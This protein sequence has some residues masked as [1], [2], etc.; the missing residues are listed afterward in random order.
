MLDHESMAM[1]SRTHPFFLV[2]QDR[3]VACTQVVKN[4][5]GLA[6]A[7]DEG[8]REISGL[9][10]FN[11]RIISLTNE[12]DNKPVTVCVSSRLRG[13]E[14]SL[15]PSENSRSGRKFDG[16]LLANEK[17]TLLMDAFATTEIDS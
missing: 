4:L 12:L 1:S 7:S 2:A 13:F 5:S 17:L 16:T 15:L 8:K 9:T 10:F 3:G 6:I 14:N 11:H